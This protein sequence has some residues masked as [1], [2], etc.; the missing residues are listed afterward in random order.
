MWA[1]EKGGE[2]RC[3]GGDE[4]RACLLLKLTSSS[5]GE[6]LQRLP[7]V[8][9]PSVVVGEAAARAPSTPP[10]PSRRHEPKS[11]PSVYTQAASLFHRSLI[12]QA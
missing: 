8:C 4:A 5:R 11:Y 6:H 7:A 10:T 3:D 2:S 12:A 1:A 9:P